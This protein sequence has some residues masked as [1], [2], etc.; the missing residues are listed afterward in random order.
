MASSRPLRRLAAA[1]L[2]LACAL[3]AQAPPVRA[4]DPGRSRVERGDR[5]SGV[6]MIRLPRARRAADGVAFSDVPDG[7]WATAAIDYVAGSNPWMRDW[8]ASADGTYRF[9]PLKLES[10]RLFAR[11]IV[12]A[13]APAEPVDGSIAFP[14]LASTD[15]F[16]AA[17]NVA[18]KL[19]WMQTGADGTFRP[20]DPVTTREA[21]LALVS[22]VGLGDLATAAEAIH[23]RNGTAF[24]V[25]QGWGAMLIGMRIGLR[26]NHGDE[27]LDVA[28]DSPLPR[29]EVAWSLYRAAT[30]PDW[31]PSYLAPYADIELPNLGPARQQIV[32]WGIDYVGYPYVW[33]G[34]WDAPT[35]DGYCCGAQ[36]VGG[37][38]C[39]GLTWWVLKAADATWDNTPPRP[40]I[41]W[42]LAQRTSADMASKGAP[43]SWDEVRA[44]DLMF[45]DGDGDGR[46]DHVDTSIGNG[47]AID[48]SSSPGGVTIMWIGTGW[49]AD[50]FTHGRRILRKATT[51]TTVTTTTTGTTGP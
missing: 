28:P 50:H 11:A 49:Y 10:R 36:P 31:M 35:S 37:F 1:S 7:Y 12:R 17:A 33:G 41:G 40:Y 8:R 32:Q 45:Y 9:R 14:D 39:S 43:L 19:G 5:G 25:P 15:R 13:F 38:D 18:V 24:E 34:E 21:H 2:A 51:P 20:A 3:L 30:M 48:S 16:F 42:S 23:L 29:S 26:Y 46:V 44:G 4:D 47:W 27:S 6:P 22:A